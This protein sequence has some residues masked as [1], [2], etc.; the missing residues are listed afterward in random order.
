MSPHSPLRKSDPLPLSIL[1][2][3]AHELRNP[4]TCLGFLLELM[5]RTAKPHLPSDVSAVDFQSWLQDAHAQIREMNETLSRLTTPAPS[6]QG[7]S[8]GLT[9]GQA[10][11]AGTGGADAVVTGTGGRAPGHSPTE[12]PATTQS[13]AAAVRVA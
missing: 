10:P 5:E 6:N 2:E 12:I 3:L 4:L 11:E 7:D 1:R 9:G 13:I 8:N